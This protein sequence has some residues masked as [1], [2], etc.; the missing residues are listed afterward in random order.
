MFRLEGRVQET[1][2]IEKFGDWKKLEILVQTS[3]FEILSVHNL[4]QAPRNSGI[5]DAAG[6]INV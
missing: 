1:L 4:L 6:I 3:H 2:A 5:D